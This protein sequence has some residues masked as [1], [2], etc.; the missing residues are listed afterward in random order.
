MWHVSS[1]LLIIV[2][3]LS[4]AAAKITSVK[5]IAFN[6]YKTVFT[7]GE[8]RLEDA[9]GAVLPTSRSGQVLTLNETQYW[10]NVQS[11]S[12]LDGQ[13][14]IAFMSTFKTWHALYTAAGS[15]GNQRQQVPGSTIVNSPYA[16]YTPRMTINGDP[17]SGEEWSFDVGS[18]P[19][20]SMLTIQANRVASGLTYVIMEGGTVVAAHKTSTYTCASA[21]ADPRFCPYSATVPLPSS[22]VD[23]TTKLTACALISETES[24]CTTYPYAKTIFKPFLKRY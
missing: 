3:A 7:G 15:D 23:G 16:L 19:A 22:F 24:S 8:P 20:S 10:N 18:G 14:R 13:I 21:S 12:Q 6:Q 5:Q 1:S 9:D 4:S 11:F 17:G 2:L